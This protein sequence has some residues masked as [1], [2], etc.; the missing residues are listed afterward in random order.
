MGIA[1]CNVLW[2]MT[3]LRKSLICSAVAAAAFASSPALAGSKIFSSGN[4][5]ATV[6]GSIETNSNQN[7]D[8]FVAQVFSLGN[9]CLRIAVT[10]QGTDTEATLVAPDGSIWQND[11]GNGGLRPLIKAITNLRG[12]YPL[13]IHS[14]N[15]SNVNADF[16]F[17][18]QRLPTTDALC[19][20]PTGPVVGMTAAR[21]LLEKPHAPSAPHI[22]GGAN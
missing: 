6:N 3:M 4:T 11:D 8:P 10:S 20:A 12:W 1:E 13:T 16:T 22:P 5:L 9:E 14:W 21:A 15:G 17:T 18:V 19:A 2:S 7:R